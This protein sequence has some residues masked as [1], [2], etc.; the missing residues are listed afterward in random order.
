MLT[1]YKEKN[2]TEVY[3]WIW[4]IILQSF[5]LLTAFSLR[6]TIKVLMYTMY[7]VKTLPPAEKKQQRSH[8]SFLV[9]STLLFLTISV[10]VTWHLGK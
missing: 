3:D 1:L 2:T 4:R 9:F 6:D 8:L 5:T 7:P 10:V